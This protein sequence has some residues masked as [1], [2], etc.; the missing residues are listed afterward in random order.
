LVTGREARAEAAQRSGSGGA[1]WVQ[2][3]TARC[4]TRVRDL[5]AFIPSDVPSGPAVHVVYVSGRV[6]LT[7]AAGAD[8][9]S[10]FAAQ[11]M[12]ARVAGRWLVA[13]VRH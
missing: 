13:L 3:Q 2:I 10:S 9:V 6:V 7:C 5:V 8:F 12:V 11:L 1:T 4:A